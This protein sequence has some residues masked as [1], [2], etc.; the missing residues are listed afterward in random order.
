M[1]H[2]PALPRSFRSV[3]RTGLRT[4]AAF[5]L[6][7]LTLAPLAGCKS[8]IREDPILR[9]AAG[10]S[11]EQ[12][13]ALMEE[14]KYARARR[15]LSHAFEIEPNSRAGREALLL[16]ADSFY[17]DGGAVNLVQAEAKYRD[18]LNRFPT[19]DR[20]DY[21]Q[22]QVARSLSGRME[23]PDRDQKATSEALQAYTELIRLYP[24]SEYVA[25]AREQIQQVRDRLAEHELM[26]ADFYLRRGIPIAAVSRLEDMLGNYPQYSARDEVLYKLGLA[27]HRSRNADHRGK[28]QE[29]FE[30]LREEHPDSPRIAEIPDSSKETE[31]VALTPE[32]ATAEAPGDSAGETALADDPGA[33]PVPD[34][35]R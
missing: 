24:T 33:G 3:L 4:G 29:T 13:K 19:S 22:Y 20:A 8:G 7:G 1:N 9:L 15:Y 32:D 2:P 10:E 17:L 26:V 21:A 30:L 25:E 11:L 18:F 14:E 28:A 16:L 34:N 35:R 27:Y 23:K 31:K 12:G 6:A 5:A